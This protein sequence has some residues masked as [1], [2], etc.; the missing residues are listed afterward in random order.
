MFVD[1]IKI[2]AKAGDGGNGSAHFLRKK[3]VPKGGPDGGDGGRGGDVVLRV[4]S[5]TDNLKAFFF[6]SMVKADD[7]KAGGENQK[8]GK[9]GKKLVIPVPQGT[10][11]YRALEENEEN[12]DLDLEDGDD[13]PLKPVESL[14]C[15]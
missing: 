13:A 10:I 15:F 5:H 11:V 6:N 4:D 7:G 8:S 12:E 1:H 3:F 9:S 2:Y 14:P